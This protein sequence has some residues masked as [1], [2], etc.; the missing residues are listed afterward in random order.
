MANKADAVCWIFQ[1]RIGQA[2]AGAPTL[3]KVAGGCDSICVN[4][5][6]FPGVG[7]IW[8]AQHGVVKC[9]LVKQFPADNHS[10][11]S[12]QPKL[13]RTSENEAPAVKPAAAVELRKG[14]KNTV[15]VCEAK[16]TVVHG[17]GPTH[18]AIR[19][20]RSRGKSKRAKEQ[21]LLQTEQQA[22]LLHW[23][24]LLTAAA[25]LR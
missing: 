14:R 15:R 8:K 1:R 11:A 2:F 10:Q 19:R 12:A 3:Q 9:L 18:A 25:W 20:R 22:L 6:R 23:S 7:G 16:Q 13:E 17:A 24:P 4:V 21:R 5:E